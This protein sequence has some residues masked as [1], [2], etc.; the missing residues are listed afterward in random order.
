MEKNPLKASEII[1]EY[2]KQAVLERAVNTLNV[3]MVE[4]SAKCFSIIKPVKENESKEEITFKFMTID[5]RKSFTGRKTV[6]LTSLDATCCFGSAT[7]KSTT[8][9]ESNV[10]KQNARR[11]PLI[12]SNGR[13]ISSI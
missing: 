13:S 12:L 3:S 9:S 1:K 5:I 4:I 7:T 11:C 10:I 2:N 8:A 6:Q